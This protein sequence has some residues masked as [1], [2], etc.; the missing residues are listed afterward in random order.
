MRAAAIGLALVVSLIGIVL[1]AR[2]CY[3]LGIAARSQPAAVATVCE[4][5]RLTFV[6]DSRIYDW[7]RFGDL[8]ASFVSFPGATAFQIAAE[9]RLSWEIHDQAHVVLQMGVNDLKLLGVRTGQLE[10]VV[11]QTAEHI[12]SLVVYLA[13]RNEQVVVLT[14]FPVG[15]VPFWRKPFWSQSV[16]HG[17]SLVNARLLAKQ[18]PHNV[19]VLDMTSVFTN[20]GTDA[21]RDTL[22]MTEHAYVELTGVLLENL[23]KSGS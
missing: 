15:P 19:S 11:S 14:V 10:Q 20:L 22:H 21:Y 5:C 8:E 4:N 7:S 2:E 18:W 16:E 3:A 12:S 23:G 9:T 17:L 1:L 6:G 13:E